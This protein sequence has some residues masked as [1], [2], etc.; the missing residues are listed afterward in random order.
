MKRFNGLILLSAIVAVACAGPLLAAEPGEQGKIRILLTTGGHGFEAE[1]FYGMFDALENVEYTKAE[2][3]KDA[4][5]LKPGLEKEYDCIV[6]YDMVRGITPEQQK[7][8]VALLKTGIGVVSLHHN[9]GAHRDWD[10]F[11]KIIGGKFMLVEGEVD[12][13]PFKKT[14]WSHDEDLKIT[15]VDKGHPITQGIDDFEIH[16]ETYGDY[17]TAPG[18]KVLLKTDH[19]KNN[20]ELAWTTSYGKSRVFFLMLGHD[21]KA[22]ANPSLRKL[23][24]QGICWASSR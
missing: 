8:F 2:L 1:P 15:V 21:G 23:I 20:P 7:A 19:P 3:P 24:A 18:I 5:L 10:E 13:K 4:G 11:R 6:M 22:Y 9:L 14:P 12:G 16:D 17:Y